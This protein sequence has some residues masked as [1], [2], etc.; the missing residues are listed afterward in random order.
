MPDPAPPPWVDQV[1]A[2]R[3]VP[4]RPFERDADDCVLIRVP[5]FDGAILR[6]LLMPRL[7]R[8]DFLI[9]LDEFGTCAWD[10]CDGRRSGEDI[11]SRLA[12]RW[13]DEPGMRLR[14][15]MFLRQLLL[16]SHLH[17]VEPDVSPPPR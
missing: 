9:R 6:R 3:P 7:R 15:A 10:A 4:A 8:P 2:V 11:A 13:P 17:A 12:E 16:Q 5:R 1:L 14:L